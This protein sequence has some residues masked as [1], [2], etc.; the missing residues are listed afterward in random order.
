MVEYQ[1][2]IALAR[3][4]PCHESL[5]RMAILL[6]PSMSQSN[7]FYATYQLRLKDMQVQIR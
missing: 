6:A 4:L 2:K 3:G 5:V 1:L 7:G